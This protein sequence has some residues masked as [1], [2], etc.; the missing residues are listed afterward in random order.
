MA[1]VRHIRLDPLF[2]LC[3]HPQ[4]SATGTGSHQFSLYNL[5]GYG[6]AAYRYYNECSELPLITFVILEISDGAI[7]VGSGVEVILH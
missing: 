3:S 7:W 5:V 1:V 6:M 2:T 4:Q